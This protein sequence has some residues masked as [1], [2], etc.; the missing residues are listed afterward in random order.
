LTERLPLVGEV[1]PTFADRVCHVLSVTEP[2]GRILGI[3]D[4]SGQSSWLQIQGVRI[5][6][7]VLP[8]FLTNGGSGTGFTQPRAYNL[9]AAWKKK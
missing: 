4:R 7:P 3:L 6:F 9:G 5:R 8:D 2:Y 1:V